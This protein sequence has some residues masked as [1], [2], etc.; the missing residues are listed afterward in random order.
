LPPIWPRRLVTLTNVYF[1][2]NAGST[3]AGGIGDGYEFQVESSFNL[4]ICSLLIQIRQ[5]RFAGLRHLSSTGVLYG[6]HPNYSV[7]SP[8]SR[9]SSFPPPTLEFSQSRNAL[10]FLWTGCGPIICIANHT[11]G[12]GLQT[13]AP[14]GSIIRIRATR[15][16]NRGSAG[17]TDVRPVA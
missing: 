6:N 7:G 5:A 2:A 16:C 1:G 9:T 11:L 17:S 4:S 12:V 13:T 14:V 8:S 10:T 3:I 15:E